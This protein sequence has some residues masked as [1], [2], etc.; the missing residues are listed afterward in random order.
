MWHFLAPIVRWPLWSPWRLIGVV[1]A[2][3]TLVMIIGEFNSDDQ[4]P[5]AEP[6]TTSA[7]STSLTDPTASGSPSAS[8]SGAPDG[9]SPAPSSSAPS[10]A[11]AGGT[12]AF[13]DDPAET[14][15][16]AAAAES[17]ASF[18]S[19]WARPDRNFKA[20]SAE[21]KPKVTTEAWKGLSTTNP[22]NTP[23]VAVSGEPVEVAINA[24]EAVFDVPTTGDFVRVHLALN[25]DTGAW[26]VSSV[27]PA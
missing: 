25:G 6:T 11:S 13:S 20:W 5:A 10:N 15:A 9:M 2:A 8:P 17:A 21:V 18:V 4:A 16:A 3:L 12:D 1:A 26:L 27:E 7:S 14:N 19:A 23:K 24:E 22:A